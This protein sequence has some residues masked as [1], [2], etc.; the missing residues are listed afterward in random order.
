MSVS[1]VSGSALVL[2]V[3]QA[4]GSKIA[5][6]FGSNS[7]FSGGVEPEL[8]LLLV[9][10]E[11]LPFDDELLLPFDDELPF[12][13]DDE[14]SLLC[15]ELL[16]ELVW[17]MSLESVWTPQ[18]KTMSRVTRDNESDLKIKKILRRGQLCI[19]GRVGV[20]R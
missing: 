15:D 19:V 5:P 14:L 17:S 11:L 18:P 1:S 7:G 10:D 2:P 9:F 20:A 6:S 13:S 16:L 8:E 3:L 12:P 4:S